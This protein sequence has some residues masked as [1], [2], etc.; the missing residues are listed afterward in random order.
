MF[1]QLHSSD[2]RKQYLANVISKEIHSR[3][4]RDFAKAL[5]RTAKT[6]ELLL[7][8]KSSDEKVRDG[9][10][11]NIAE[12]NVLELLVLLLKDGA[13]WDEIKGSAG[14]DQRMSS[15]S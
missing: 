12:E 4:D 13:S 15:R 7:L 9:I 6:D 11:Q 10:V 1:S 5:A 14:L 2:S 8:F 3:E